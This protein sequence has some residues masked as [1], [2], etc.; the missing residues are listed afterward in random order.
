M[1][2]FHSYYLGSIG[3]EPTYKPFTLN[4]GTEMTPE[5]LRSLV[6]RFAIEKV[7]RYDVLASPWERD[8]EI[9]SRPQREPWKP[10]NRLAANFARNI[11]KTFEGYYIGVPVIVSH[12]EPVRNKWLADYFAR[13]DQADIDA[14]ISEGCSKY[15]NAFELLYS[16]EGGDPCSTCVDA[17]S[18]FV[19]YDNTVKHLPM[20][21]VTISLDEE[22]VSNG[23]WFDEYGVTRYR[24]EVDGIVFGDTEPHN[25]GGIPLI[26]YVQD[27][28]REGLYESA[29]SL[30][31]AFNRCI[32]EK[33]NDVEYFADAYMLV[34]GAQLP[35]DFKEDLRKLKV[36][37]IWGSGDG[38]GL[39]VSFLQKPNAD[40]TQENLLNRL[41]TLL[42]K[43]SMVPD[44]TDASFYT[45]SGEALE[46]RLM[47]MD[48]MAKTKDRKFVASVRRRLKLLASY[49]TS[50][51]DDDDWVQTRVVMRRNEPKNIAAEASTASSL[52]GIVSQRTQLGL[53]SFV[54]NPES[55]IERINDEKANSAAISTDGYETARSTC[56]DA[57]MYEITSILGKRKRGEITY[58][59]AVR[60][61]EKIG[62]DEETA[63]SYL[64]DRDTE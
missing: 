20:F 31:D 50:P 64:D 48:N 21:G 58:N 55:E 19:V 36:I 63:R 35:D 56:R 53:L 17:R 61:L 24:E 60:M 15:G 14:D 1:D 25:F 54:D 5:L 41:E 52:S 57:T 59:N 42:Y 4:P 47:P 22:G 23:E 3:R 9:F 40:S 6:N 39:G 12:D 32:S 11:T 8:F 10:D 13:V 51:L 30:I 29:M 27:S 18:A 7:M 62:V 16:D 49:P 26:E 43:T 37:N 44:I 34:T 33:A 38:S 46:K 28:A 45:A 2:R